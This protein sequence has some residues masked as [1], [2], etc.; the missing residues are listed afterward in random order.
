MGGKVVSHSHI[1]HDFLDFLHFILTEL[2][3][4]DLLLDRLRNLNHPLTFLLQTFKVFKG[5]AYFHLVFDLSAFNIS[6]DA[7]NARSPLTKQI[8]GF[9]LFPL[10]IF[11]RFKCPHIHL[12]TH[13]FFDQSQDFIAAIFRREFLEVNHARVKLSVELWELVGH[14]FFYFDAVLDDVRWV[15]LRHQVLSE[16]NF[17]PRRVEHAPACL[18][19]RHKIERNLNLDLTTTNH[20]QTVSCHD[21]C[22]I[23]YLKRVIWWVD[24]NTSRSLVYFFI[25]E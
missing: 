23:E 3:W 25:R 2:L 21:K 9:H 12:L 14:E 17:D 6:P 1:E 7:C 8:P 13:W 24:S 16:G 15:A 11:I 20:N 18:E 10:N 22:C 5:I 4:S 19:L